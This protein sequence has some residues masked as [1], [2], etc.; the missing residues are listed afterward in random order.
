M[1]F[2]YL[3]DIMKGMYIHV[4]QYTDGKFVDIL[5]IASPGM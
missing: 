3:F 5:C 2:N 4:E 1:I